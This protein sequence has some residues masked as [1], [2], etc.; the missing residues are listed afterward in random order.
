MALSAFSR[1]M[2]RL[3]IAFREIGRLEVGTESAVDRGKSTK[4]FLMSMFEADDHHGVEGTDTFNACYGGTNAYFS[5]MNWMQGF[6]WNGASGIVV[7]SDP[8]VHPDP[9]H[10]PGV[11]ASAISLLVNPSSSFAMEQGRT[12][13][14][15]HSWDFYRPVG[16]LTND[17]VVDMTIATK[18]YEEAM[19]WCQSTFSLNALFVNLFSTY[20]HVAYHNNA[21][22]HAKRNL[23]LMCESMYGKLSK[24]EH[25]AFFSRLAKAGVEISAE[26]ATTY[27]CPLYAS[28]LSM[29]IVLE[30]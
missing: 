22:Y 11:G 26:N 13:F 2:Q 5:T 1:F 8:A 18:Q 15:K 25:E 7:C 17:A 24:F 29:N 6:G 23:R 14:I 28:L 12:T 16:W 4:S 30:G 20:D 27:T 10:L 21:P 19:L 9:S 3:F